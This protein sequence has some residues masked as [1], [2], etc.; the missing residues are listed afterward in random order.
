[1]QLIQL[2]DREKIHQ[3]GAVY[4]DICDKI[5]DDECIIRGI[6]WVKKM[7]T[8]LI[9]LAVDNMNILTEMA[10][11]TCLIPNRSLFEEIDAYYNKITIELQQ[12]INVIDNMINEY[13]AMTEMLSSQKSS[14]QTKIQQNE[15]KTINKN[16]YHV[17]VKSI[18]EKKEFE[19]MRKKGLP[20][21]N[22][23]ILSIILYSEENGFCSRMRESQRDGK[24]I[25]FM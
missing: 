4:K 16:K 6:P 9:H 15:S 18:K 5:K 13:P 1:M 3:H 7:E 25:K 19:V 23:E 20:L 17:M 14:L 12:K 2:L 10:N 21:T 24:L 11:A 22:L 8:L